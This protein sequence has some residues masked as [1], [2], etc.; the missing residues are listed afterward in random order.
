M[1]TTVPQ[2]QHTGAIRSNLPSIQTSVIAAGVAGSALLLW[3]IAASQGS[4][5]SVLFLLGLALG[6]TLFHS[7]FGFTSAWRQLVSVGQG[8]ALQAHTVMLAL[9]V[10]FFA[11]IFEIGSG[12]FGTTPDGF[13]APITLALFVGAALFGIGMQLGGSCASGTLFATGSGNLAVVITLVGFITGSGLGVAGFDFWTTG[14]GFQKIADP[15]SL[16]TEFGLWGGVAVSLAIIATIAVVAELIIRRRRPPAIEA[17]PSTVG[18][19]RILRGSW[20]IWV[21][22]IVLA[23]LNALVLLTTG[24]PWGVTSA[25]RLWASKIMNGVGLDVGTWSF[26]NER[27]GLDASLL[28]DNTSVANFGIILGALLA[29]AAAGAFSFYKKVP[30]RTVAAGLIGGVLMGYGATFAAGCNIGA[31]FSGIASGSLHGYVWAV[32]AL[33]GTFIGLK[34]RPLFALPVPKPTDS[35]C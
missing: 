13:Y 8:R 22:A 7:R 19:A 32:F 1:T 33:V 18:I 3:G 21:G 34:L 30:G 15:V 20:P 9:A 17:V 14:S 11:I 16:R 24:R 31:Y 5:K 23:V 2:P 29:S 12:W 6:V 26:W 25:F 35:S 4:A 28:A 10:V 27:P